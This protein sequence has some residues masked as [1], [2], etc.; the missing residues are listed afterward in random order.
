MRIDDRKLANGLVSGAVL[1]AFL[2]YGRPLLVPLAFALLLWAVLNALTNLLRRWRFP[3]WFAWMTAFALIGAALYFAVSVLANEV[4]AFAVQVPVY[5]AQLQAMAAERLPFARL[6]PK[7]D[8]GTLLETDLANLLGQAASFVSG[9]LLEL[10]LVAIFVGFLLAEQR[11]LPEKLAR[12]QRNP[13]TEAESEK[14]IQAIGQ[15]IQSYLGVCTLLSVVMGAVSFALL[16][17]LGVDFDAFWAVVMF[18]LTFIP[19][20]GAIGVGLP[21][22]AALAQF[23]APGTAVII[24]VVLGIVHVLLTDVLEPVLLGRSL[25][26]SP[27]AIIL[28]LA[29]WGLIW[30]I[31]GLFLAVPMTGAIA[32]ACG[33]I[34]GLRWVTDAVAGPPSGARGRRAG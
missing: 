12:L 21:A 26:L 7:I 24:V 23:Q 25:N 33:H 13:A 28:S 22:L 27:L 2:I 18:L 17:V 16:A 11:Y 3:V 4:G 34:E 30:G 19:T 14:L 15:Q 8:L 31:G 29:F 9:T 1:L 5:F 6:L 10:G 32:I 20:V